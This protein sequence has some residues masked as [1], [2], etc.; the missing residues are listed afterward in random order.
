M[1]MAVE[2]FTEN[3]VMVSLWPG[4]VESGAISNELSE[5]RGLAPGT[6]PM[7]MNTI[8]PTPLAETPLFVG[9]AVAAFARDSTKME[10]TGKVLVPS[11][12]AAGY[13][14]VDERGLRSPPFTSLKFLA[15]VLCSSLLKRFDL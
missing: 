11:V 6:P 14:L 4:L 15:S 2:L 12:M 7:D 3:I 13:G 5:R 9:R 10:Y 1:G 8:L